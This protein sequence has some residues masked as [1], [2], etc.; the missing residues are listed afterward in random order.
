VGFSNGANIAASLLLTRPD[1]LAGGVLI[2]AMVPFEPTSTP[3]LAGKA[4]LLSEGRMDP[5]IPAASAERL[6]ALLRGA[7]GDVEL[8]WQQGG[9]GLTNG[10]VTVARRWLD[11]RHERA[12][13]R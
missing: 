11:E 2:R 1:L 12:V 13:E 5:L 7:G 9:H 6:A 8:V 3:D 10:D 4:V